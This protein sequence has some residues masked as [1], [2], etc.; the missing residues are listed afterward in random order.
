[1]N[2]AKY[3]KILIR[4]LYYRDKI[5]LNNELINYVK[6]NRIVYCLPKSKINGEAKEYWELLQ[7]DFQLISDRFN[8]E[9]I[10]FLRMTSHFGYSDDIN[11]LIKDKNNL[12]KIQHILFSLGYAPVIRGWY[13]QMYYKMVKNK[14]Q[15]LKIHI[16]TEVAWLD[17]V[18]FNKIFLFKKFH[19]NNELTAEGHLL[20]LVPHMFFE[21]LMFRLHYI[22][23]AIDIITKNDIDV[24]EII[25]AQH[26]H[27][28]AASYFWAFFEQFYYEVI[29]DILEKEKND[30]MK[31]FFRRINSSNT[32]RNAFENSCCSFPFQIPRNIKYSGRLDKTIS[33]LKSK[34]FRGIQTFLSNFCKNPSR[35]YLGIVRRIRDN[36]CI[37]AFAGMD[38]AGK[39]SQVEKLLELLNVRKKL[40]YNYSRYMHLGILNKFTSSFAWRIKKYP[41]TKRNA[42]QF[43]SKIW[44]FLSII[45]YPLFSLVHIFFPWLWKKR[46]IMDRCIVDDM[47]DL[48]SILPLYRRLRGYLTLISKK[49]T[50]IF[51]LMASTD[52]LIKRKP[53]NKLEEMQ[54]YQDLYLE[55][56]SY[57]RVI[58]IDAEKSVEEVHNQ[59]MY[60]LWMNKKTR[61]LIFKL[62]CPNLL[63]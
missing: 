36:R 41:F 11:I 52:T 14:K 21:H 37:I 54:H 58:V 23:Q 12:N 3:E 63:I 47:V 1:M 7:S 18:Y 49:P 62:Q 10:S 53:E 29:S 55:F 48:E 5:Q 28:F 33:D 15:F 22:F 34:P 16:H 25:L 20:L 35:K 59:I 30:N 57:P 51:L 19:S 42:H 38:G 27:K 43:I 6:K 9:N 4:N 61:S 31:V 50:V 24:S 45:D 17:I 56:S 60:H 2:I 8:E 13:K 44:A 46:L 26:N 40:H 39:T 32:F